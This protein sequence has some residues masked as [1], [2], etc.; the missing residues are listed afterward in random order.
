MKIIKIVAT[1]RHIFSLKCTKFDFRWGSASDPAGGAYYSAPQARYTWISGVLLLR[2]GKGEERR[3][4]G[5][6]G[7]ERGGGL[8]PGP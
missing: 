4:E 6:K 8:H 3:R 1:R 7:K 2:G 5:E